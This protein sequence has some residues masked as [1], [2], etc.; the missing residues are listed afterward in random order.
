MEKLSFGDKLVNTFIILLIVG[1]FFIGAIPN[2]LGFTESS[3]AI[4]YRMVVLGLSFFFIIKSFFSKFNYKI[5]FSSVSFFLLFWVLYS[6]RVIHDLY[7]GPIKLFP[8]TEALH[9]FLF[10]FGVTFIPTIALFLIIQTHRIDFNWVL[11]YLYLFLLVVL[12]ITLYHRGGSDL[13]GR[14]AGNINVGILLFGQYG[15]T[16]SILSLFLLNKKG[17]NISYKIIYIMGFIIGFI[18]VFV[19]ASKSPF[20]ALLL[21]LVVFTVFWYGSVKSAVM[22]IVFGYI[23][24][25]FFMEIIVYL[26]Q[27]F[28]SNFL[29]RLLYSIEIGGDRVRENLMNTAIHEFIESPFFGNAMLIQ[30]E[31]M[32]GSYPHNLIVEAFM[33]LGF[34]GGVIFL[35]WMIRS[36]KIA[37]NFIKNRSDFTWVALLYIQYLIFG[38][39]SGN[40]FSSDLFCFFSIMLLCVS[41]K[42]STQS[43]KIILS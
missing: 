16:L 29:D 40:L 32:V 26:N 28:N 37:V 31:G 6:V 10:A 12:S 34:L 3:W 30:T 17:T 4:P 21:V 25:S 19:S 43:S 2:V 38:M 33:S 22:L 8:D 36:L 7:I 15:T 24:I 27:Y 9:Y 11:K 35:F 1:F 18:G 14:T 39:F 23:V 41:S 20:L 42:K 5:N 13:E